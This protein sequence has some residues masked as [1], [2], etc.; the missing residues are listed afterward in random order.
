[1]MQR[2]KDGGNEDRDSQTP[3]QIKTE[4]VRHPDR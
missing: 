4:T 3:R 1:M 2:Q